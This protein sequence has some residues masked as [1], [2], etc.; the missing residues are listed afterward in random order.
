[1]VSRER[2]TLGIN[3][4]GLETEKRSSFGVVLA[5]VGIDPSRNGENL[6]QPKLW[7]IIERK[8]KP[9]TERVAGQISFPGETRKDTNEKIEDTIIGGLAEFTDN[10]HT[11]KYN[12]FFIP[13][14]SFVRG[15]I[16]VNGNPFDMAILICEGSFNNAIEP[17]DKD[18]VVP[19]GWMTIDEILKKDPKRDPR[20]VRGFVHQLA[21]LEES[22]GLIS[23]AVSDFFHFPTQRVPL[24]AILPDDFSISDF[25]KKREQSLDVIKKGRN[26]DQYA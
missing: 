26:A 6:T 14:S 2:E 25:F 20:I 17:E 18:E 24:G 4:L 1:M 8:P 21:D 11:I 12:L 7:T 15:R 19:N 10:N 16:F 13:G 5:I 22:E 3:G 9:E 23:K